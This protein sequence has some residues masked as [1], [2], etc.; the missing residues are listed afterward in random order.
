MWFFVSERWIGQQRYG[1]TVTSWLPT[2]LEGT[3]SFTRRLEAVCASLTTSSSSSCTTLRS[4]VR[5]RLGNSVQRPSWRQ[6][7]MATGEY[8]STDTWHD[9]C[10]S[11]CF[12][13]VP[14]FSYSR[15]HSHPPTLLRQAPYTHVYPQPPTHSH[16][17]THNYAHARTNLP[18][19]HP[20]TRTRAKTSLK[21]TRPHLASGRR[22][23]SSKSHAL[24]SNHFESTPT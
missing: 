3:L 14:E 6:G 19:T 5:S 12:S 15:T 8:A 20:R 17:P 2:T 13:A 21:G 7:H 9:R 18:T 16:P 11:L 22:F 1:S 4:S 23:G 24:E 10:S